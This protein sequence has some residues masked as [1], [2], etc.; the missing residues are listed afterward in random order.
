LQRWRAGSDMP[1]LAAMA[2]IRPHRDTF[3]SSQEIVPIL[4]PLFRRS[5]GQPDE[6]RIATWVMRRLHHLDGKEVRDAESRLRS[7][8]AAPLFDD[9]KKILEEQLR[10][11]GVGDPV[12][13]ELDLAEYA[14]KNHLVSL[15]AGCANS[16]ADASKALLR[17]EHYK[18]PSAIIAPAFA[19]L[20]WALPGED[21]DWPRLAKKWARHSREASPFHADIARALL[22]K[23]AQERLPSFWHEEW[24]TAGKLAIFAT[25]ATAATAAQAELAQYLAKALENAL[26]QGSRYVDELSRRDVNEFDHVEIAIQLCEMSKLRCP[27]WYDILLPVT[28]A[29]AQHLIDRDGTPEKKVEHRTYYLQVFAELEQRS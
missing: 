28:K 3:E 25:R 19:R 20:A 23:F 16:S 24:Q 10:T 1:V 2:L 18:S 4:E 29:A 14:K 21:P 11:L 5:R 9:A 22:C 12:N 17:I 13:D 26:K 15:W 8:G 7:E 6:D 27:A